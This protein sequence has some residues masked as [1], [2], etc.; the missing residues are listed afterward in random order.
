MFSLGVCKTMM[1]STERNF[2]H[3]RF[4][5]SGVQFVQEKQIKRLNASC[6][7]IYII[8]F[9]NNLLILYRSPKVTSKSFLL[10]SSGGFGGGYHYLYF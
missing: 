7:I 9:Q 3:L 6:F 1:L 4:G 8:S 2:P 10:L 5:F